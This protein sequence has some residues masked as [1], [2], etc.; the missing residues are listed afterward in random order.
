MRTMQIIGTL[1]LILLTVSTS[2]SAQSLET[3]KMRAEQEAA[4]GGQVALTNKKCGTSL[5]ARI[6]WNTFDEAEVLTKRVMSWCQAALDAV[7]DICGDALGKEA[8]MTKVKSI[9][10][11]GAATPAATLKDGDLTFA[12]SLTPNQNK[13]LVRTYL[14]KNL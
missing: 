9:T 12:F 2:T 13:L 8:L 11:A 3:R 6:D 1:S 5:T 14:E 4:L 7:E 10:C